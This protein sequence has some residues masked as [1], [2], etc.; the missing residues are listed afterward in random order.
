MPISVL[1][2]V[3]FT[4]GYMPLTVP[5]GTHPI[6][7]C[8]NSVSTWTTC[9]AASSLSQKSEAEFAEQ[10]IILQDFLS[11]FQTQH[12]PWEA[13]IG[14]YWAISH[15]LMPLIKVHWNVILWNLF[16]LD[17]IAKPAFCYLISRYVVSVISIPGVL[18]LLSSSSSLII[19]ITTL[20]VSILLGVP[21]GYHRYFCIWL[22]TLAGASKH[23][24]F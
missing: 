13:C 17:N 6:E 5:Y 24:F 16:S 2:F 11:F 8:V 22:F 21:N 14:K 12:H 20:S 10:I 19:S 15:L 1:R 18:P 9:I 3:S 23:K 7:S 4:R